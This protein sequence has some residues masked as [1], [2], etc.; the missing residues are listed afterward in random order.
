MAL[1]SSLSRFAM[2]G[3]FAG[4]ADSIVLTPSDPGATTG[5]LTVR[6]NAGDAVPDVTVSVQIMKLANGT[7]GSGIDNPL[8]TGIT[9]VNGLVEFPGLP[10]LATYRS[11]I[12][13]N[14]Q[15][16]RGVTEDADTTPLAGVLGVAE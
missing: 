12:G 5:Y 14:G 1:E 8:A 11:K 13:T 7:T 15:W 16:F 9:D 6:D 10:R 3:M 2:L 4:L